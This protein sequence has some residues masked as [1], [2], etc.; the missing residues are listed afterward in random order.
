M[1]KRLFVLTILAFT[2]LF[3]TIPIVADE[4]VE[5]NRPAEQIQAKQL[6]PQAKILAAYLAKYNSPLQYHAQDLIDAAGVYDL[7]WK[8]LPAIAGVESTFGKFTPGGYNGWGWGVYGA[9]AVYFNSWTDGIF[10]VAKGLRENYFDRGLTNPYSINRVYAAS[11]DWGAKVTYFMRDLEKFAQK[12]E[13]GQSIT[14]GLEIRLL[15]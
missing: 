2:I 13:A 5:E 7:D 11:P 8:M 4:V 1:Y 14:I 15:L 6:D 3:S 9:K 10:T 12:Y